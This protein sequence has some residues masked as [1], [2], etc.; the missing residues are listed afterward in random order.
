MKG[1]LATGNQ[2]DNLELLRFGRQGGVHVTG[3]QPGEIELSE[4]GSYGPT[5][6]EDVGLQ[7]CKLSSFGSAMLRAVSYLD[8]W[9]LDQCVKSEGVQIPSRGNIRKSD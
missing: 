1:V 4:V 3:Y 7:L 2:G 8:T 5:R 6:E 9:V